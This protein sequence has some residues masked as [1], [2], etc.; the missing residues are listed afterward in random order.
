MRDMQ[1]A[2]KNKQ[3][4][5]DSSYKLGMSTETD[6]YSYKSGKGLS[7]RLVEEISRQKSEPKWMLEKRLEAFALYEK[8]P[9]PEWGADLSQIQWD[10]LHYYLKPIDEKYRQESQAGRQAIDNK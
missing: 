4:S 7:R 1:K 9:I 5:F 10:D 3:N 8:M 2:K 6:S